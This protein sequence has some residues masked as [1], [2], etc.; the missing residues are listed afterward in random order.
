LLFIIVNDGDD[1]CDGEESGV[2]MIVNGEDDGAGGGGCDD[3][4]DENF[5][6]RFCR[7]FSFLLLK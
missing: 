3:A 5:S 2:F 4:F 7:L 1:D 6:L